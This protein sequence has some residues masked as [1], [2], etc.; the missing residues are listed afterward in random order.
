MVSESDGT[1]GVRP[2]NQIDMIDMCESVWLSEPSQCMEYMHFHGGVSSCQVPAEVSGAGDPDSRPTPLTLTQHANDRMDSTES[3][4]P[5]RSSHQTSVVKQVEAVSE[6][7]D[8]HCAGTTHETT[9]AE[10]R[11]RLVLGRSVTIVTI[12]N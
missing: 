1:S 4:V 3:H 7:A 6:V 8:Q 9:H 2:A 11:Q 12:Y 10:I 5:V